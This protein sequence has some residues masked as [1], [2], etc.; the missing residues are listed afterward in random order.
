MAAEHAAP[1][2]DPAQAYEQAVKTFQAAVEQL[3]KGDVQGAHE[4]FVAL[5][6]NTPDEPVLAERARAYK[7]IC[8]RRLAAAPVAPEGAED[9]YLHAVIALNGGRFDE[10]IQLLDAALAANPASAKAFY[11]R[12]SA[13]ALKGNTDAAVADLRQ[14]IAMDPTTRFQAVNDPD[15]ERIREEPAF[16][17]IIEPTSQNA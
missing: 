10:A 4:Q 15:F 2:G 5:E 11:A 9:R 14:C 16:I 1:A 13:Y 17:D 6:Q 7:R 8:E 12:A 3:H